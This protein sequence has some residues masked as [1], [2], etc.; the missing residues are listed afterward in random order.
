V[1]QGFTT[2]TELMTCHVLEDP[3]SP[4]PVEG[5][6]VA[7]AAFYESRFGVQSY[8]FL[9]LLLKYSGLELHHQAPSRI[10]LIMAFLTLSDAFMGIDPHFDMWNHFFTS[11]SHGA[12]AWK[13]RFWV[14]WSS[15]LNPGMASIPTLTFPCPSI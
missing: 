8:Q 12:R 11:G 5:Y 1:S 14:V 4:T 7:F 10:L 2:A 15:M 9:H 3:A 13:W 6:V